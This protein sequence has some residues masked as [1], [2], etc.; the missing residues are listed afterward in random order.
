[1]EKA[2]TLDRLRE[3]LRRAI[4]E[5][6]TRSVGRELIVSPAGLK[7][8]L[9]YS[10]STL[11]GKTLRKLI[12]WYERR[13]TRQLTAPAAEDVAPA[14]NVLTREMAPGEARRFRQEV[15]GILREAFADRHGVEEAVAAARG[16]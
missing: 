4:A 5:T 13:I 16:E 7:K 1:M 14:V 6:S 9:D 12:P 11:Y 10:D 15:A 2:P 3:E 8:F